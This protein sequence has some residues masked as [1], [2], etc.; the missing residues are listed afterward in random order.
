MKISGQD[1]IRLLE[2]YLLGTREAGKGASSPKSEAAHQVSS[3]RVE[4]SGEAKDYQQ[5]RRRV[6]SLPEVRAERVAAVREG[7][8][9]GTYNVR[10][11]KVA[12]SLVRTTLLDAVL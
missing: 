9:S 3:D 7:V 1:P 4:I 5:I 12:E 11:E 10:G 2:Y 8:E 6:S